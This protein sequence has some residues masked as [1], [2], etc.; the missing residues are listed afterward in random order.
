[1]TRSATVPLLLAMALLATPAWGQEA[2]TLR[3][4]VEMA[5]SRNPLVQAA[6]R[7]V[8]AALARE[9]Q[10][11][12]LPNPN[13]TLEAGEISLSNPGG[14]NYVAGISQPLILGGQREARVGAARLDR[15]IAEYQ[16]EIRR[17]D[18]A[19]DVKEAYAQLL[20]EQDRLTLARRDADSAQELLRAARA[21]QQAGEVPEVE[22]LRA[23]V[24]HGRSQQGVVTAENRIGQSQGRLN[25][26]LGREAQDPVQIDSLPIPTSV[27]LPPVSQLVTQS[28]Q[29]RV[30]LRKA[31][32]AIQREALQRQI[33]QA[34]LW[35]GTEVSVSAGTSGGQPIVSGSLTVP[36]PFYRQQGEV[37]EAEA[38]RLR[39]EAERTALQNTITLEVES[40]FREAKIAVQQIER[41]QRQYLPQA[42]RLADNAKR[43]FLAGEGSGVEVID[44]RRALAET[45][46]QYQQAIFEFRQALARLERTTGQ[47]LAT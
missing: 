29:A 27:T 19:L 39:A 20:F 11:S 35:T 40:A 14:G 31:E 33:A 24:E 23:E 21:L 1:M 37:A 2:L 17:Q 36:F 7:E 34:G 30:E 13:L 10:A 12:A 15:A 9:T 3:A 38:N 16:R 4:A 26:L 18:L 46:T 43:R 32:A 44:A 45:R 25:V 47:D 28:L 6:D 5:L 41:Y 42:E 22:V 8:Q